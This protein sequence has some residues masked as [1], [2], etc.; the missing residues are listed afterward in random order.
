V[1]EVVAVRILIVEDEVDNAVALKDLLTSRLPTAELVFA[2]DKAAAIRAISAEDA[3]FDFI[4]LDRKIPPDELS[5]SSADTA[6]GEAVLEKIREVAPAAIICVLTA[7]QDIGMASSAMNRF[8]VKTVLSD[9]PALEYLQKDKMISVADLAERV[10]AKMVDLRS[11]ILDA[12]PAALPIPVRILLRQIGHVLGAEQVNARAFNTGASTAKT[13][14]V[15]LFNHDGSGCGNLVAKLDA[16]GPV[17]IEVGNFRKHVGAQLSVGDLPQLVGEPEFFYNYGVLCYRLAGEY[18]YSFF[19]FAR[20]WPE[21]AGEVVGRVEAIDQQWL[22]NVV[23]ERLSI[24]ELLEQFRVTEDN[25]KALPPGL[26]EA[27]GRVL[28]QT[29]KVRRGCQHSDLH[30]ENILVS[31]KGEPVFIDFGRVGRLSA[32][33]DAVTLELS[34][35]LHPDAAL[36]RGTWPSLVQARNWWNLD[37]FC[38]D[39]PHRSAVE[40]CRQWARRVAEPIG[41][42]SIAAIALAYC[43]WHLKFPK[44]HRDVALAIAESACEALLQMF[45]KD[46]DA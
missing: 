26:S 23:P 45:E 21:R 31:E 24:R 32:P 5:K 15:D 41:Q 12:D 36:L 20:R 18:P 3:Y 7:F 17:D 40:S 39:T 25:L 35:A 43:L 27:L 10:S 6:H 30:G 11:V 46:M 34:M 28:D 19:E 33:A 44:V 1:E 4:V 38:A 8:R 13:F 29:V 42:R 9:I 22:T 2:A 14:R 37:A 16:M